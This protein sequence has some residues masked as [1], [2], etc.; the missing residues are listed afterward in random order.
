MSPKSTHTL[1]LHNNEQFTQES[2]IEITIKKTA[3]ASTGLAVRFDS[4]DS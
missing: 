2:K 3:S 4:F 1:S